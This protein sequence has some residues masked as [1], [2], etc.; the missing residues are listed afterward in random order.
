[1]KKLIVLFVFFFLPVLVYAQNIVK[2][3]YFIDTDPGFGNGVEVP[4]NTPADDLEL[5]FNVDF[6]GVN[7]GHHLLYVRAQDANGD[8]SLAYIR[9]I[10]KMNGEMPPD[11]IKA[12]YFIDTDPG[13]G[14][15][16]DVPVNIPA[17]DLELNFNVDFSGV[18]TGHHLLYIRVQD[19]NGDWSLAYIRP[20]LKIN[21]EIPPIVKVEY[22]IDTDPGLGNGVN[23]PV[24]TLADDLELSFTADLSEVS[25]GLHT[26][27]IRAQ[28]ADGNWSLA[29]I[30]HI[31]KVNVETVLP[32]IV[33]MEYFIDKDP[34]VGN[35][36]NVPIAISNN[37]T[38]N[39]TANLT[40]IAQGNHILYV[41]A[42]D[43]KGNWSLAHIHQFTLRNIPDITG[44]VTVSIAGHNN[45]A[46]ANAKVVLEGTGFTTT[47]DSNGNF[48]LELDNSIPSG[49]YTL[50]ITSP[51]LSPIRKEIN[52]T[53]NQSVEIGSLPMETGGIP[54]Q[55]GDINGDGKISLEEAVHALQVLSGVKEP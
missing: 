33:K 32:D 30:K 34:G 42:L 48:T 11:I 1:M 4:V 28:D 21:G 25:T 54:G 2:V 38:K 47:T 46:V 44:N 15:G 19:A 12:E 31:L 23:V 18:N 35:G 14:N 10:L 37:I 49:K 20:I 8:W 17:D 3:E 39:F 27:Y 43:A 41:R 9:P 52:F 29:Y 6:S 26:L 22:F 55:V 16:V 50:V 53:A 24:N 7:T 5:D 51:G 36:V 13:L 40:G 45:L